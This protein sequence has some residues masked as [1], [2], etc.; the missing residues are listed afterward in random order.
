MPTRP[1][2]L[3][4]LT[5]TARTPAGTREGMESASAVMAAAVSTDA[6]HVPAAIPPPT[7]AVSWGLFDSVTHSTVCSHF[8]HDDTEAE[9]S[10]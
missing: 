1:C 8:T 9:R 5:A 7:S 6:H 4:P 10:H 3:V 2:E